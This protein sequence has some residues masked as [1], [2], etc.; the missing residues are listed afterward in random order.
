VRAALRAALVNQQRVPR[1]VLLL[2]YVAFVSLGLPDTVLG[3][4]WPS[5]RSTFGLPQAAMGTALTA[6]VA[7]YLLQRGRHVRPRRDDGRARRRVVPGRLRGALGGARRPG[8]RLPGH[9]AALGRARRRGRM[10]G[11]RRPRGAA[12]ARCPAAPVFPMLM[13]RTPARLGA[14]VAPHAVGFQVAAATLGTAALPSACGAL[15]DALG[16]G[17]IPAAL[18]GLAAVVAALVAR[19]DRAPEPRAGT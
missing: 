4:A 12:R 3:V 18:V 10:G 16:A 9:P 8:A 17:A 2:A 11:R 7:G 19:L 5:L 14:Q 13:S 1:P 15:A 6:N